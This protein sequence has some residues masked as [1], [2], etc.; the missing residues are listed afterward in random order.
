MISPLLAAPRRLIVCATLLL[1]LAAPAAQEQETNVFG[2]PKPIAASLIGAFYDLKQTQQHRPTN[3]RPDVYSSVIDYY[4]A[5]GWDDRILET[6]YQVPTSLYA[7]QIFVPN[8]GADAAPKAFY[9]GP[10]VAPSQ[11]IIH[12]KG[13]VSPPSGGSY[14]FWGAADDVMAVAVNGKTVLLSHRG[15][16]QMPRTKWESSEPPG[17]KAADDPLIAGDWMTFRPG[18]IIDL[19]ILVGER[20]GGLFNAFLLVEKKGET[21]EKDAQGH[22]ILPIFQLAEYDTPVHNDLNR[23]PKFAKGYPLWT[24]YQ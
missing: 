21:Y 12:Y 13:Q 10:T 18:Q 1:S 17:A 23:E 7:S 22:P 19:D 20:P 9:A 4:L 3:M 16:M 11:W 5:R 24:G 8:M 14:R 6:Y 15:D 2:T